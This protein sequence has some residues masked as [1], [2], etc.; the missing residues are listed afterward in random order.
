MFNLIFEIVLAVIT[1]YYLIKWFKP[2]TNEV[3]YTLEELQVN[4]QVYRMNREQRRALVR[5]LQRHPDHKSIR[6]TDIPTEMN[7]TEYSHWSNLAESIVNNKMADMLSV[8]NSNKTT[9][10]K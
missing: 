5:I 1:I 3:G 2:K 10:G 8:T 7:Y 6:C 4:N 9:K